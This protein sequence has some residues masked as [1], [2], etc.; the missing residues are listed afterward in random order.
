MKLNDA[1][2]GLI[3]QGADATSHRGISVEDAP[4]CV[5]VHLR[6]DPMNL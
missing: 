2:R 1:A 5:L 6:H 3:G 4:G